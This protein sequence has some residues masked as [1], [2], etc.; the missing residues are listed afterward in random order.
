V[1]LPDNYTM[2]LTHWNYDTFRGEF[3]NWWYGK[4]NVQ[5]LLNANGTVSGLSVDGTSYK[6]EIAK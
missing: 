6:K 1:K 2:K 4:T 5:F 3:S